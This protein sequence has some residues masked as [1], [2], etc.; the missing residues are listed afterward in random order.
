VRDW[1]PGRLWKGGRKEGESGPRLTLPKMS[2]VL[3]VVGVVAPARD[4]QDLQVQIWWQCHGHLLPESWRL[5]G[6]PCRADGHSNVG[7]VGQL[8]HLHWELSTWC[9]LTL[10]AI[11]TSPDMQPTALSAQRCWSHTL[12]FAHAG[13]SLVAVPSCPAAE[14]TEIKSWRD[15]APPHLP[16]QA[17]DEMT[18]AREGQR[19]S[20]LT[21]QCT[22]PFFYSRSGVKAPPLFCHLSALRG[23]SVPTLSTS[24]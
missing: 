20:E 9:P 22:Q 18:K 5:R 3:G 17:P 16:F 4:T 7:V 8:C 15:T 1:R 6:S 19:M 21:Q 2:H 11:S 10:P 12:A 24:S 13:P 14:F 23:V